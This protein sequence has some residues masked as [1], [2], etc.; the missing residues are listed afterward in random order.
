MPVLHAPGGPHLP[1]Q[2]GDPH[3]RGDRGD[4][5]GR[6]RTGDRPG[7]AYGRRAP[8]AQGS[9]PTGENAQAGDGPEG[10][11]DDHQRAAAGPAGG[12]AGRGGLGSG[13]RERRLFRPQALPRDHP[14]RGLRTGVGGDRA[15]GPGGPHAHQDQH[16]HLEGLQRRRAGPLGRADPGA[17]A[18]GA[19]FRADAHRRGGQAQAPGRVLQPD[20]AKG[21]ADRALRARPRPAGEGERPGPLL[22]RPGGQGPDR[23]H[24]P[25][26]RQ[27]LRLL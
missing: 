26:Q 4:R 13:E 2:V 14:L 16:A 10:A 25:D 24:H 8:G 17:R 20:G 19:L 12:G 7:A 9:S 3:V 21:R 1:P 6:Q 5:P 18:G 11:L 23:L 15:R 22:A 27:V